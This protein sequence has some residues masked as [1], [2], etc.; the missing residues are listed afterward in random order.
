MFLFIVEKDGK[1]IYSQRSEEDDPDCAKLEFYAFVKKHG[2]KGE[3]VMYQE[4]MRSQQV[5]TRG[6]NQ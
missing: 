5:T 6:V 2:T 3:T 4:V 1:V